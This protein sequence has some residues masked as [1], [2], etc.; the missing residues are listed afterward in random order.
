M[1]GGGERLELQHG[2]AGIEGAAGAVFARRVLADGLASVK[3]DGWATSVSAPPE[4][5]GVLLRVESHGGVQ[6]LYELDG[7]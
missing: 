1:A 2:L 5:D 3:A 6:V 7:A 4:L